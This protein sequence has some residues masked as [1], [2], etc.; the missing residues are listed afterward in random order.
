V[1]LIH[2]STDCVFSGDKGNYSEN[3]LPDATDFY[4]KTKSLGEV[5]G[6]N[7]LTLR[8][9]TLGF[10]LNSMHGLLEW[11]LNQKGECK[12]YSRAI[13]SGLPTRYFSLILKDIIM[14]KPGLS[15]L[16]HLASDPI[17]K[18]DVLSIIKDIFNLNISI[19]KDESFVIDRSLNADK[20]NTLTGFKSPNWIELIKIMKELH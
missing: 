15:G 19:L 4:G 2:I 1:R 3:D 11:F 13:F 17:S 16:Y 6:C 10:E 14:N 20:Y 12:G 9:S 5:L 8:I 18:F 7:S